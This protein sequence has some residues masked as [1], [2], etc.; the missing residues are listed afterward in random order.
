MT[1]Q[2]LSGAPLTWDKL[3]AANERWWT[4]V[5][6]NGYTLPQAANYDAVCY[7]CNLARWPQHQRCTGRAGQEGWG[8][9][10]CQDSSHV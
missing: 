7:N 8:R 3:H 6:S 1:L 4:H 5:D 10:L 9:C 2:T